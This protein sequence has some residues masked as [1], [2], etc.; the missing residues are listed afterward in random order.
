MTHEQLF[1]LSNGLALAGWLLLLIVPYWK[2]TSRITTGVVITLLSV[3]YMVLLFT[4]LNFSD[5]QSFS[6]LEGLRGLFNS[7]GAVLVG[8]IHYLAFDMMVGQ[9]IVSN[10]ARNGVNR[11]VIIPCLLLTFMAGPTGL[12]LYF[13][14]RTFR[15][16]RYFDPA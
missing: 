6:S 1:Q 15:T 7:D 12:V 9:Y 3:L 4:S 5:F 11:Y 13:L 2:W 14:I 10:A 16:R 8:W